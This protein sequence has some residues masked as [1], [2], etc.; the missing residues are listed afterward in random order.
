MT[1]PLHTLETAPVDARPA[2]AA[3]RTKFGAVPEAVAKMATSPALLNGFLGTSAAFEQTTLPAPVREVVVMTVAVRND[4]RTCIGIHSAVLRRLGREDLVAPLRDDRPLADPELEAAR[5][6][7]HRIMDHAGE[8][9]E[10]DIAEFLAAG[11]T[12]QN[13]LEIVFGIG[14]YTMSTYANR[15]LRS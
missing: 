2:L 1:F 15:L 4:C 9:P 10:K 5:L 6:L 14:V 12:P 8:V 7:V 13:A 11:F 3:V